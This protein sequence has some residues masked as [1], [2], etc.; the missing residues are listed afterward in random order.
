M[1]PA[2]SFLAKIRRVPSP[3]PAQRVDVLGADVE[4]LRDF[5]LSLEPGHLHR[6]LDRELA[7]SRARL[8]HVL[9]SR[10][11]RTRRC[12]VNTPTPAATRTGSEIGPTVGPV[13]GALISPGPLRPM[14]GW[15]TPNA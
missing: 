4:L 10:R 2:A 8:T 13:R 3:R 9:W 15:P 5:S 6:D 14:E 11:R 12:R 7:S 1:R